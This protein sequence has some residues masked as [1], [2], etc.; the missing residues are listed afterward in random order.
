[1]LGRNSPVA[2][3]VP[4]E[5]VFVLNFQKFPPNFPAVN[6]YLLER[7]A[8]LAFQPVEQREPLFDLRQTLGRRLNAAGIIAER[9]HLH[10]LR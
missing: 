10:P 3:A 1:M 2:P 6:E 8:I 5:P 9:S 7:G 4:P